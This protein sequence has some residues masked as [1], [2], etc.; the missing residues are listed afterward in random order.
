MRALFY[1]NLVFKKCCI[2]SFFCSSIPFVMTSCSSFCIHYLTFSTSKSE[3]RSCCI[4]V[5]PFSTSPSM[6]SYF[7]VI[8]YKVYSASSKAVGRAIFVICSLLSYSRPFT[9][10]LTSFISL[11]SPSSREAKLPV[12]SSWIS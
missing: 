5:I 10:F 6:D 3:P 4:C 11:D 9:L 7:I 8:F 2:I 1:F 12:N